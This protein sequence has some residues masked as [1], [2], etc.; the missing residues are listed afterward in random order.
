MRC[1]T[2]QVYERVYKTVDVS[3]SPEVMAIATAKVSFTESH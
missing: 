1:N 3:G 2:I